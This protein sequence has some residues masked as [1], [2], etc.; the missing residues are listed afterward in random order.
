MS[1]INEILKKT[2]TEKRPNLSKQS[3]STYTSILKNL[4]KKVYPNDVFN[5]EDF[6]Y[7]EDILGY[8]QDVEP[9]KRKTIL[10]AL[11]I[12][13]DLSEYRKQ[14]LEDIEAYEDEEGEQVKNERQTNSWVTTQDVTNIFNKHSDIADHQ[15][16]S[17]VKN[18][19]EIQ[20]FVILALL[21]GVFIPPRRSKDYVEFKIKNID[22]DKDNY[23]TRNTLIFNNYKTSKTYG[24]QQVTIP[25]K[26]KFILNKWIKNNP[27]E[28]LLFD[29]NHN[30]LSNVKL[31]QRLNKIFDKKVSVNQLRHTYLSDK[32][33]DSI[34]M[35]NNM[36]SDMTMMGTSL[37][38]QKIYIK[39]DHK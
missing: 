16:K 7:Y 23:I 29:N 19:Q 21:G 26:L 34:K 15:Y 18:L 5:I 8:L 10:S 27:T 13:T 14:M 11:V 36:Q 9:R 12:I 39:Q 22:Y 24:Q 6:E 32:Y 31:T 3:V 4:Y 30:K 38:Q 28:Y 2:I 25:K 33:K 17:P 35:S 37:Q 20:N 1:N